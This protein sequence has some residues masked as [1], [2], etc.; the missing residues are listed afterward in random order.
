MSLKTKVSVTELKSRL[1][2]LNWPTSGN[3]DT[4]IEPL[5]WANTPQSLTFLVTLLL[6]MKPV[7]LDFQKQVQC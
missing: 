3:K 6:V 2:N 7:T 4:L 5:G 1:N